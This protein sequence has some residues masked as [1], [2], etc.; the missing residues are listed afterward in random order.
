MIQREKRKRHRNQEL[1]KLRT[2]EKKMVLARYEVSS[3][4]CLLIYYH[5]DHWWS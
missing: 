5:G 4:D 1:H 2:E 3:N